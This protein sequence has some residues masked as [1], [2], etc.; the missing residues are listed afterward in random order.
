[1]T[2]LFKEQ[3]LTFNIALKKTNDIIYIEAIVYYTDVMK[4]ESKFSLFRMKVSKKYGFWTK[5]IIVEVFS[6]K[7]AV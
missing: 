4:S 5:D 3:N 7:G 2:G 1:M 6:G